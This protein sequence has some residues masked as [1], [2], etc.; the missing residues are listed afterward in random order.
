MKRFVPFWNRT[1]QISGTKSFPTNGIL[2]RKN[3]SCSLQV[4]DRQHIKLSTVFKF[5]SVYITSVVYFTFQFFLLIYQKI[6]NGRLYLSWIIYSLFQFSIITYRLMDWNFLQVQLKIYLLAH[7]CNKFN[8]KQQASNHILKYW[9]RRGEG[10]MSPGSL[11]LPWPNVNPD[12]LSVDC[13]WVREGVGA[14]SNDCYWVG[15]GVGALLLR[16][17][18]WS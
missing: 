14:L 5:P 6:I 1:L 4:C 18:H 8:L 16:Y 13:C 7:I 15:G 9:Q 3:T 10:L 17:W 2:R 11:P 12:L